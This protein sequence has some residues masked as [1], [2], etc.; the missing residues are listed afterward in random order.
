MNQAFSGR[1]DRLP[2]S[3]VFRP[4]VDADR[5]FLRALY[6]STREDEMRLL[7]WTEEQKDEFLTQQFNAQHVYYHEQF[8][9]AEFLVVERNGEAIGRIYLDRRATE[10]RLVDIAL[11]PEARNQ[12]LGRALLQDLLD[13]GRAANLPVS[14]H[15]EQYNPAMRLYLRLGFRPIE[16]KGVYQLLEWHPECG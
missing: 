13:E 14:I 2:R 3:L 4:A 12:G 5:P 15:V 6:A 11:V 1:S 7:D 9:A 10:L 16:D 8:P